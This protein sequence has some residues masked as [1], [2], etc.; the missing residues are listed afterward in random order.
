MS[1]P[2]YRISTYVAFAISTACLALMT[3]RSPNGGMFYMA[4]MVAGL[5]GQRLWLRATP[6]VIG[7]PLLELYLLLCVSALFAAAL[8]A[9]RGDAQ[10]LAHQAG[11]T[12]L[13][14]AVPVATMAMG[15]L[16]AQRLQ[17]RRGLCIV[18]ALLFTALACVGVRW[19]DTRSQ[20]PPWDAAL[21]PL[22]G[23]WPG[24]VHAVYGIP[25]TVHL[26]ASGTSSADDGGRQ[27]R[28]GPPGGLQSRQPGNNV[29]AD[30]DADSPTP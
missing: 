3:T 26:P 4:G 20:R 17:W 23:Y 8:A 24:V 2:G 22:V 30:P 5:V 1:L 7:W 29:T 11:V 18:L 28:A 6:R 21:L 10:P 27:G 25:I 9:I 14:A 12:L 16:M 15:T 19:S 13:W